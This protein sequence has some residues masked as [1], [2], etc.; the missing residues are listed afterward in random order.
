MILWPRLIFMCCH[1]N[2]NARTKQL[3]KFSYYM[4]KFRLETD[5][6]STPWTRLQT[7]FAWQLSHHHLTRDSGVVKRRLSNPSHFKSRWEIPQKLTR[8]RPRSHPRHLV[9]IGTAQKDAIKDI[10]GDNQANS[11]FPYRWPPASLTFNIYFYL[12]LYLYIIRITINNGKPHLK[13][14]K[15]QHR[16]AALGRSAIKLLGGGGGALELVCGRPTLALG[17]ALVHQTKQKQN[18]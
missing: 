11:C 3:L 4:G 13:P 14:S 2:Q 12:F 18:E 17:S 16:R 7:Q 1:E 15:N 8:L 5:A 9:R 6:I 10:T